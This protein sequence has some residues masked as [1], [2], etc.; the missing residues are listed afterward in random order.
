VCLYASVNLDAILVFLY[1]YLTCIVFELP[2]RFTVV[3]AFASGENMGTLVLVLP[4]SRSFLC[5]RV[6]SHEAL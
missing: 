5:K 4:E 3:P 2:R 6:E 1:S